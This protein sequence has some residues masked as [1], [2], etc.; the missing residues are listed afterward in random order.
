M[1]LQK[2]G[3][4][5]SKSQNKS[6]GKNGKPKGKGA[7][8]GWMVSGAILLA[9]LVTGGIVVVRRMSVDIGDPTVATSAPGALEVI[10]LD[11]DAAKVMEVPSGKGADALYIEAI[12]AALDGK[13]VYEFIA[14]ERDCTNRLEEPRFQ[15]VTAY[16]IQAADVG[17]GS[18]VELVFK[19][20]P[21]KGNRDLAVQAFLKSLGHL[22]T[23]TA[24]EVALSTKDPASKGT[25][26][27]KYSRAAMIY[28]SRLWKHG[29]Y[30]AYRYAG[31]SVAGDALAQF[32]RFETN[33]D[34]LVQLREL[35][36]ARITAGKKWI[37]KAACAQRWDGKAE[38]GDLKNLALHDQDRSWRL[39]G[40]MWFGI[41]QWTNAGPEKRVEIQKLL[42]KLSTDQ[43]KYIA[44]QA[45][46]AL[47]TQRGDVQELGN[48]IGI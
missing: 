28:A 17:M 10:Q 34:K 3:S 32:Q 13:D 44:E 2:S 41:V 18:S 24:E 31:L 39:Q 27:Y 6:N 16:L 7:M 38:P 21:I 33:S 43:D 15:K 47:E 12:K 11:L 9:V 20:L 42:Q 26:S 46:L 35:D 30:A 25:L 29:V 19:D 45:R 1:A 23:N 48:Q 36:Q 8:I 22:L 37:M 4:A 40:I 14:K 5:G